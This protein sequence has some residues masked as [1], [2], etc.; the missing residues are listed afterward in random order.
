MNG[1]IGGDSIQAAPADNLG[2]AAVASVDGLNSLYDG[3]QAIVKRP[4]A[5]RASMRSRRQ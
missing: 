5:F 4:D 2:A 3:F 1:S